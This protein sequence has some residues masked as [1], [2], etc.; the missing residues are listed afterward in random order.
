MMKNKIGENESQVKRNTDHIWG[1]PEKHNIE[2]YSS[3]D[4]TLGGFI[5]FIAKNALEKCELC[6]EK[7]YKH[8]YDIYHA[9]GYIEISVSIKEHHPLLHAKIDAQQPNDKMY[10]MIDVDSSAHIT[11]HEECKKW[12]SLIVEK[13]TLS[14]NAQEYSFTKFIE[15]Y[16][17]NPN[18]VVQ[19]TEEINILH[20]N[21]DDDDSSS[22][23]GSSHRSESNW[24]HRI[25][26]DLIRTFTI[27]GIKIKV[28]FKKKDTYTIDIVKFR[29]IDNTEY[30]KKQSS[31]EL[32]IINNNFWL[33]INHLNRAIQIMKSVLKNEI[34]KNETHARFV[35]FYQET[36]KIV[37]SIE[38]SF[39]KL[40][41]EVSDEITRNQSLP[42]DKNNVFDIILL[43][44]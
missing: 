18:L 32:M 6:R 5:R 15:Q 28:K 14:S 40:E 36:N 33:C 4:Q 26:R 3:K 35:E 2:F 42:D 44:K 27:R 29:D 12:R 31:N 21:K 11:M 43:R 19:N 8:V 24:E 22:S 25:H 20:D 16:F 1:K 37:L 13:K 10:D 41:K 39:E 9:D 30:F 34:M 17:Y 7:M 23:S 38:S